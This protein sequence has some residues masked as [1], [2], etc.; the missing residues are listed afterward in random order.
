MFAV[1]LSV[2][3]TQI[4]ELEEITGAVGAGVTFTV[5]GLLGLAHIPVP[6]DT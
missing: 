2:P 4:G 1:K 3:P 5:I 6:D